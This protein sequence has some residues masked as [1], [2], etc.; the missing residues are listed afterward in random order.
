MASPLVEVNSPSLGAWTSP[1]N[2]VDVALGELV[3]IRLA[4]PAG[5]RLWQLAVVGTDESVAAPTITQA[6]TVT[7]VA[8]FTAPATPTDGWALVI[9]SQVGVAALGT[10]ALNGVQPSYTTTFGVF[11]LTVSG[12]RV[13]AL[14][15]MYEG[16]ASFGWVTKFNALA[17]A[18]PGA[19]GP[20]TGAAAG[21]W[22]GTF[23]AGTN[24]RIN[25]QYV[26][27]KSTARAVS[28][29]NIS[30][31]GSQTVDGV[32]LTSGVDRVLVTGQ[33]SASAN[34]I[35]LYNS[36][37][38]W[39]RA[40]D[41]STSQDTLSGSRVFI[42][43]GSTWANT[44]WAL[45][46]QGSIT[47]GS[48]ALTFT[49]D[50]ALTVAS[51]R[52]VAGKVTGEVVQVPQFASAGDGGGG[53]FVWK[54]GTQ[55]SDDGGVNIVPT[56]TTAGWWQRRISGHRTSFRWFGAKGDLTNLTGISTTA[57]SS[58]ITVSGLTSA[59]QGKSITVDVSRELAFTADSSTDTLTSSGHQLSN[60]TRV[61]V[62][63]VGGALPTG[64]V[65]G[66]SYY[67]VSSTTN[68]L[69]LSLTSG[70]N[71]VDLQSAGTGTNYVA[72][73]QQLITTVSNVS[74]STVTLGANAPFTLS[75]RWGFVATDDSAAF[76]KFSRYLA[77]S[78]ISHSG[79]L[80]EQRTPEGLIKDGTFYVPTGT[81]SPPVS[82]HFDNGTL[83]GTHTSHLFNPASSLPF[84]ATFRRGSIRHYASIV[85][86][87]PA[88]P[89]ATSTP[90]LTFSEMHLV[91]VG[92]AVR[93][94]GA[95]N[96]IVKF[97]K[98][99]TDSSR[100][101]KG[102]VVQLDLDAVS[103]LSIYSQNATNTH[104]GYL[105]DWTG[106][107]L[108]EFGGTEDSIT[109]GQPYGGDCDVVGC[110]FSPV[111]GGS[112]D[113]AWFVTNSTAGISLAHCRFGGE[114][115]G[116][117]L[118]RMNEDAG[119]INI[120]EGVTGISGTHPS[121]EFGSSSS[122]TVNVTTNTFTAPDFAR[123]LQNN[124][125]VVFT[126]TLLSTGYSDGTEYYVVNLS[127]STF[128]IATTSGG[129]AI[130]ITGSNGSGRVSRAA[131]A[132]WVVSIDKGALLDYGGI[133]SPIAMSPAVFDKLSRRKTAWLK[134][135]RSF[136]AGNNN[137]ASI[138]AMPSN[139][140]PSSAMASLHRQFRGGVEWLSQINL[141]VSETVQ[142]AVVTDDS[143]KIT[144][145]V[146]TLRGWPSRFFNTT[147]QNTGGTAVVQKYFPE[148]LTAGWYTSTFYYR[149]KGRVEANYVAYSTEG[150]LPR[151]VE[152]PDT[153][154]AFVR[155]HYTWYHNGTSTA[156]SHIGQLSVTIPAGDNNNHFF[157]YTAAT[158]TT[159]CGPA[160]DDITFT[161]GKSGSHAVIGG[162]TNLIG[163]FTSAPPTNSTH[164]LG[165]NPS[166]GGLFLNGGTGGVFIGTNAAQVYFEGVHE[167]GV[168]KV[169]VFGSTPVARAAQYTLNYSTGSRTLAAYT[170]D[171]ESS[172]YT[173]AADGEAKLSDINQLRVAVENLRLSH[174]NLLQVFTQVF[175]DLRNHGWFTS[176]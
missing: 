129:S 34:G 116:M 81:S 52:L 1:T 23:P 101:F 4:D 91:G 109:L 35:Y 70:G 58:T 164:F 11:T 16:S 163:L 60:G 143:G 89:E 62:F 105:G 99:Q 153:D 51:L 76:D 114:F 36:G 123:S 63:N 100:L 5:S 176:N 106:A 125:K 71:A 14:N 18:P 46:T 38:A 96:A 27:W 68:T 53:T 150:A 9:R 88:T 149:S 165:Y 45:T 82:L 121:F 124:E 10:D 80:P 152:L 72:T 64:L 65:E 174:D 74:G 73:S 168:D 98:C 42:Y 15:E 31:S 162:T 59:D 19:G 169:A 175:I 47:L 110:S 57:N 170:T 61:N 24:K 118:I 108:V 145:Q 13:G 139:G 28:T 43:D 147:S 130:D 22:S 161:A 138:D 20:P 171:P 2:G 113:Q 66:L 90:H 119:T 167:G 107:G 44:T 95:I 117:T 141:D 137:Y 77:A 79:A 104:A 78:A 41:M 111:P 83:F 157:E 54:S 146:S 12:G 128:Q 166:T 30:L 173:G 85:K 87:W 142:D 132:P 103:G 49:P 21:D 93:N 112:T 50:R 8:T 84:Y 97:F 26:P 127:G 3:S 135:A 48:T 134:D 133:A 6:S 69:K 144:I 55:P 140:S 151:S 92:C 120:G 67:V 56:V 17:K 75:G 32:T 159:G 156:N 136:Q 155:A 115:G 94:G 154:G 86:Y 148:S 102:V 37:G 122:Y 33:T 172:A 158:L 29:S 126:D 25:N 7:G 160:R 40:S 131:G 39:T